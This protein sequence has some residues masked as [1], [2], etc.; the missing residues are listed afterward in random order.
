MTAADRNDRQTHDAP[1]PGPAMVFGIALILCA[2][3]MLVWRG[4]LEGVFHFDDYGNIVDNERIRQ[5]WPLDDFLQ[6]NRPI[7]LYSFAINY[8]FSGTDTYAYHIT[9]LA[10]H[11]TSGLLLYAGC[12]LM[13]R[14]YRKHWANETQPAWTYAAILTAGL[15]STAWVV[16][17]LTTQAVTNVVQRYESLASLG[18]LGVWVGMLLYLDGRRWWGMA[19][20]LPLAWI[21]L[22]SKEVFAT[23]PLAVLLLD[24]LLT[25][26]PW[27]AIARLRW[28]PYALMIS[29]FVW[30]IPSVSR[31][32][33][34]ERTRG[35]SMGLG[36]DRI[37]PWEYLRT[38]AEVIWHYVGLVVWPKD[39]C[40]DYVW[41]IQANPWIYLPLGA[42]LIA[43]IV[44]ALACYGRAIR[45]SAATS[46][47]T[48]AIGL[49]GWLG[50]IF[51]FILAPTSSFMPIADIAVEHRMYL[52]SATII[53]GIV[54]LMRHLLSVLM[55]RS[56]RPLVLQLGASCILIACISLLAWRTHLRNQDY[57]D[58]LVLW[59]TAAQISPENPRVWYNLGQELYNRGD[60]R[61]A[62]RPMVSAVGLSAT[63]VPL[64]DVGLAD[65][66]RDVGRYQDAITLYQRAI[67]KQHRFPEAYNNLG[68]VFF[69]LD[70]LDDAQQAFEAAVDQDH[71]EAKYNLALVYL[72]QNQPRQAILLFQELID[73]HPEF[74]V[75]NRR[76]AW[77]LATAKEDSLRDIERAR[78]LMQTLYD[79][80]TTQSVSVLDTFGVI[81]AAQG[82]FA[83]AIQTARQ[84]LSL[85]QA[86][87][88]PNAKLIADL[89]LRIQHYQNNQPWI[90]GSQP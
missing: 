23:A 80:N 25:R 78:Q 48:F 16:H 84:A 68:A 69:K 65:T 60:K 1:S 62:L 85:A 12:L 18:Y 32:F 77:I 54:L 3:W 38:Q 2:F 26:Q 21:G 36:M 24:R 90:G 64:F 8:H 58:G 47:Q 71:P 53:A 81:Q 4:S 14:L 59:T 66:L 55:R 44:G 22:M 86:A 63:S 27:L 28:L 88:K 73:R 67:S 89:Q 79:R 40:F 6:N 51:F 20:I 83:T 34:T 15:I 61:A 11:I 49:A 57:R 50:L 56:E 7:G 29:P 13:W 46:T 45:Q 35:S 52:A 10:I 5:L 74:T 42:A 43:V 41:R 76:L 72:R 19:I 9:N 31:F 70:R 37:T 33:D 75:A 82:D 39:L 17:P 87:P 30:F